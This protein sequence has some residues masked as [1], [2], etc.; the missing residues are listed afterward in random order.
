MYRW[1]CGHTLRYPGERLKV[2]NITERCRK[3]RLKWFGRVKRRDQEYV[4]SQTLEKVPPGRRRKK[5]RWMDCVNR[6]MRAIAVNEDEVHD[7][8]GLE[9][10]C[11]GSSDSTIKWERLEDWRHDNITKEYTC[12]NRHRISEFYSDAPEWFMPL[13]LYSVCCLKLIAV[14][15]IENYLLDTTNLHVLTNSPTIAPKLN[16]GIP[17]S[18]VTN[19]T[20]DPLLSRIPY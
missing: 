14:Q 19:H 2:E 16:C 20:H 10:N 1:A 11:V 9:D 4:G 15:I 13:T 18:W 6:D 12:V 8:A 3:A 17:E 5:Q 7:M